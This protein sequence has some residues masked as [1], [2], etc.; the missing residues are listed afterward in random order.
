MQERDKAPFLR[1]FLIFDS[2]LTLVIESDLEDLARA[3]RLLEPPKLASVSKE[4]DLNVAIFMRLRSLSACEILMDCARTS[5]IKS[6][7]LLSAIDRVE[8]V[9]LCWGIVFL[10]HALACGYELGRVAKKLSLSTRYV[11]PERSSRNSS[12]SDELI[13]SS[14]RDDCLESDYR[15]L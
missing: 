10:L 13:R 2:L 7:W 11:P 3:A 15:R 6:G 12:S 1:F 9:V 8:D 5:L 14:A 4:A